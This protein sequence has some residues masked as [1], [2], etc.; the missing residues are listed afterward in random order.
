MSYMNFPTQRV[1]NFIMQNRDGVK[2][3]CRVMAVLSLIGVI[4]I[5]VLLPFAAYVLMAPT[6][7]GPGTTISPSP[8]GPQ[9]PGE[10][11]AEIGAGRRAI[12][13]LVLVAALCVQG[14]ALWFLRRTFL[15]GA[16]GRWFSLTAVQSFRRFA[17]LTLI[18][19]FAG[20]GVDIVTGAAIIPA[21]PAG[22]RGMTVGLTTDRFG[23]LFT[24]LIMLFVAHMFAAG[25]EVDEDNAAIL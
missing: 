10:V 23:A 3:F 9:I 25:R 19:V 15:E 6:T 22:D 17:W 11:F 18:F 24:A 1:G 14:A 12:V 5:A 16:A 13:T 20:V 2:R 7:F 8:N 4:G 21:L